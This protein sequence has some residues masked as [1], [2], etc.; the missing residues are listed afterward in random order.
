MSFLQA[1]RRNA[2]FRGREIAMRDGN[3]EHSWASV[4]DRVA[5]LAGGLTALGVRPGD[6]VALLAL[7]SSAYLEAELAIWWAGAIVVPLNTRWA[8]AENLYALE[9]CGP[10]SSSLTGISTPKPRP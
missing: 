9:D 7:N 6:C 4:M 2:A 5:R 3:A 8:T 1:V 10:V